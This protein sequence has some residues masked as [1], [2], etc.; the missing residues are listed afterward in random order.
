MRWLWLRKGYV[1]EILWN[2]RPRGKTIEG[3]VYPHQAR[4]LWTL[5]HFQQDQKDDESNIRNFRPT[6]NTILNFCYNLGMMAHACNTCTWETQTGLAYLVRPCIKTN[7]HTRKQPQISFI[8]A[9]TW[10][11]NRIAL[12]KKKKTTSFIQSC[13][14]PYIKYQPRSAGWETGFIMQPNI[15]VH[16]IDDF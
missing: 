16:S 11:T 15:Y 10:A 1:L 8:D 4:Q 2:K 14:L 3:H 12:K 7:K 5:G 13:T 6:E 9:E